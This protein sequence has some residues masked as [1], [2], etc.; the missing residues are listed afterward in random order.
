MS[1]KEKIISERADYSHKVEEKPFDKIYFMD[2]AALVNISAFY[3][4]NLNKYVAIITVDGVFCELKMFDSRHL[5]N[6]Y[7]G[8]KWAQKD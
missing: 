5:F 8:E 2:G 6:Q 4:A 7:L 3:H 1:F